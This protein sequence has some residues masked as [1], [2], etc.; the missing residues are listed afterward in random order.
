MG[1]NCC[2]LVKAPSIHL[3]KGRRGHT[4]SLDL[5]RT[6]LYAYSTKGFLLN[7]ICWLILVSRPDLMSFIFRIKDFCPD[8]CYFPSI[9]FM[10]VC[11]S[12]SV[13]CRFFCVVCSVCDRAFSGVNSGQYLSGEEKYFSI[14]LPFWR[15]FVQFFFCVD[16][17]NVFTRSVYDSA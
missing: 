3:I 13:G 9:V 15:A 4:F 10:S 12:L 11:N 1:R 16:F 17:L 7:L 5:E 14:F 6:S 2:T 8:F